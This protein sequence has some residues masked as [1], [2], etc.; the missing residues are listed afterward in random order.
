M[1]SEYSGQGSRCRCGEFHNT[2]NGY[3]NDGL[4]NGLGK[5]KEP[6]TGSIACAPYDTACHEVGADRFRHLFFDMRHGFVYRIL[7]CCS[8]RRPLCSPVLLP[9]ALSRFCVPTFS[10]V[11][12]SFSPFT[13][14][15][16][17]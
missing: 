2:K 14:N 15:S 3:I 8:C 10:K 4:D 11:V 1:F 17:Y 9:Y 13:E 6:R 7:F 12:C 16:I 5:L